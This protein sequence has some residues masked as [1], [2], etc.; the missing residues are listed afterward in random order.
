MQFLPGSAWIKDLQG[1]YVFAN[2]AAVN[3]FSRPR[4][5]FYGKNDREIFPG[6]EADQFAENDHK[7]LA[8]QTGV[9]LVETL[10]QS[11]GIVHHSLVSKFP[12]LGA[13]LKPTFVGGIAIDITDRLQSERV[14][15]ESEQRFRQLAENINEVFWMVDVAT[16]EVLYIS[17]AY[18]RIW[19]RTC[20]SLRERP[21][22]FLDA[23]HPDDLERVRRDAFE[24]RPS[25]RAN[26]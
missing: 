17:P 20:Q 23:V 21:M 14:R 6:T 2:D 15:A 19:G 1:R 10:K 18:E 9:Q 16:S 5:S 24:Q 26:R 3:I 7:A 11:D 4:E 13:D 22:S 25:S 8:S 12:I